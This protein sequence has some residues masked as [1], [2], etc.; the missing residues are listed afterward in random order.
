MVASPAMVEE[1]K[2]DGTKRM[3]ADDREASE[4]VRGSRGVS[5]RYSGNR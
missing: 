4:K 3:N 2:V 1:E 5:D